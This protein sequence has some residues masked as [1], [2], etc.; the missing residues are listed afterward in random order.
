MIN[1]LPTHHDPLPSL[2]ALDD[3]IMIRS[4]SRGLFQQ[5]RPG[6]GIAG[7][8]MPQCSSLL[9]YRGVLSFGRKRRTCQG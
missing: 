6:A 9:P 7:I 4:Y 5:H 8:E 2:E 1:R 3:G